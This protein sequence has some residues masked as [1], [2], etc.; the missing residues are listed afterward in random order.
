MYSKQDTFLR[1]DREVVQCHSLALCWQLC[2]C[3]AWFTERVE[4][5]G[6][7]LQGL[8]RQD[9]AWNNYWDRL[10]ASQQDSFISVLRLLLP[11]GKILVAELPPGI[12]QC[13]CSPDDPSS[14]GGEEG[15]VRH[16]LGGRGQAAPI[17]GLVRQIRPLPDSPKDI[18]LLDVVP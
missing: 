11:H 8:L 6:P 10:W 7:G 2:S 4:P 14:E 1:A 17:G 13:R 15:G 12:R 5:V 16:L 18:G 3:W 9:D